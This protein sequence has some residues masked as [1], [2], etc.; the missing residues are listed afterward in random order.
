MRNIRNEIYS[1]N[2]LL[3]QSRLKMFL[4]GNP[5]GFLNVEDSKSD[6]ATLG[7]VT[8]TLILE[9]HKFHDKFV[10]KDYTLPGGQ[11]GTFI[12]YLLKHSNQDWEDIAQ[13]AYDF[14]KIKRSSFETFC[15]TF[16]K[17]FLSLYTELI[18]LL[19]QE[20]EIISKKIYDHAK[21]LEAIFW[22]NDVIIEL[23]TDSDSKTFHIQE[24]LI[25]KYRDIDCI[26]KPDVFIRNKDTK[27]ITLID[28]KTTNK[29]PL[30][31]ARDSRW[32]IQAAFYKEALEYLY[33]NYTV[34]DV[35]YIVLKTDY[36]IKPIIYRFT[37]T[38]LWIGKHG[39]I[40]NQTITLDKRKETLTRVLGFDNLVDLFIWHRNN[41]VW[42]TSKGEY[43]S[44]VRQLNL[45]VNLNEED[46]V[47]ND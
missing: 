23:F 24:D 7:K 21:K 26:A 13:E 25:F 16:R 18:E 45:F 17:E 43:L 9:K 20:K 32:D 36:L 39:I 22:S 30:G 46:N 42:N 1:D 10:V 40:F 41:D 33:P 14:S 11:M 12:E 35:L 37:E 5:E 29:I 27:T 38:D 34:N 4:N 15:N 47:D 44:G 19:K 8:E 3:S 2:F 6:A 28:L 31:S